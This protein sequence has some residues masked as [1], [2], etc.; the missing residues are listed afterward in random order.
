MTFLGEREGKQGN[1]ERG[2]VIVAGKYDWL[3]GI[4]LDY[5]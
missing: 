1:V 5:F 3:N 4:T 2:D